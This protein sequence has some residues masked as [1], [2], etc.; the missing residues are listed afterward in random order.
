MDLDYLAN[1]VGISKRKLRALVREMRAKGYLPPDD[2]VDDVR[3]IKLYM[4]NGQG[5]TAA[6]F[7]MLLENPALLKSLGAKTDAV[8][9]E[10]AALGDVKAAAL[11]ENHMAIVG[12][13]SSGDHD[14]AQRL[15]DWTKATLPAHPVGYHYLAVRLLLGTPAE[16]RTRIGRQ[17]HRAYLA[18]CKHPDFRDWFEVIEVKGKRKTIYARPKNS[19]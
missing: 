14:G 2:K 16:F 6:Q 8:K 13:A 5:L 1:A 17:L 12:A 10:I 9:A 4:N 7:V 11:P 3:K 15:M 19:R 18:V